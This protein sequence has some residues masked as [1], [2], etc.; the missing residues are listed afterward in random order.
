[1]DA[2]RRRGRAARGLIFFRLMAR[3]SNHSNKEVS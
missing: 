3:R 1:V 2:H